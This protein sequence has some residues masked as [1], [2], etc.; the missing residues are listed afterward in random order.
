MRGAHSLSRLGSLITKPIRRVVSWCERHHARSFRHI[1]DTLMELHSRQRDGLPFDK[2]MIRNGQ[3]AVFTLED[4]RS[5]SGPLGVRD[6]YT[7]LFQTTEIHD[8]NLFMP[9]FAGSGALAASSPIRAGTGF[10]HVLRNGKIKQQIELLLLALQNRLDLY[11]VETGFVTCV[12]NVNDPKI[13]LEFRRCYSYIVDDRGFYYDALIPSRIEQYL[14]SEASSLGAVE[15]ARARRVIRALRENKLSKYNYQ[16]DRIPES[17]QNSRK[18]VLVLDQSRRDASVTRGMADENTFAAM[19]HAALEENPDSDIIIKTHPDSINRG[20]GSYYAKVRSQGRIIKVNEPV[21][22]YSLL[23]IA[24][25]VYVCSSLAGLEALLCEKETH[26]FGMPVYAGWGLTRDRQTLER[27]KKR[28]TLEELVH[29]LYATFTLYIRPSAN[30][31]CEVEEF[32]EMLAGLRL[33][34]NRLTTL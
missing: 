19:L 22:P 9:N 21:N 15:Q 11:F 4:M 24:D 16:P 17:M 25:K 8:F 6:T 10:F 2:H 29:A 12:T 31:L 26:V 5:I 1:R 28:L 13:P 32:L 20:R 23:E 14:N 18:K 27:R 34:C 30:T 7:T 3:G 33:Q